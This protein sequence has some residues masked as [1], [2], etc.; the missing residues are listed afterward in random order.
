[1]PGCS[2]LWAPRHALASPHLRSNPDQGA[3]RDQQ[4]AVPSVSLT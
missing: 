1:M 2:D 4:A 3:P